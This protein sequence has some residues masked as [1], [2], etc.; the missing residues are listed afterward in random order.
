MIDS[1]SPAI[2]KRLSTK[3]SKRAAHPNATVGIEIGY[4]T[5]YMVKLKKASEGGLFAEK[6]KTFEFDP[7]LKI[8]SSGFATVLKNALKKFCGSSKELEIW[9]MP[10]LDKA[11]IH[12]IKIPNV[13][14]EGLPGAVYWGLQRE[15]AF[16]EDETVVD[17]QIEEGEETSAT[18]NITGA[19]I[20]RECVQDVQQAFSQTGYLLSG[21]GLPLLALRNLVNLHDDE[22]PE[23]PVLVCQ[24]GQLSTTVSVLLEKRL[25]FTRN[26]P[27]GLQS[28]AETLVKEYDSTLVQREACKIVLNLGLEE[29]KFSLEER[30]DH[31]QAFTLLRP[32][33]ERTVRQIKRTVEYYQSNFDSEPIETIF[34]GGEIAARG[35]LFGFIAQQL[36]SKVIAIDPF[37]SQEL[38][39]KSPPP[40]DKADRIAFGPAFGLAIEG[41]REGINFAHTYKE[42]QE[43]GKHNKLAITISALLIALL[44]AATIFYNSQRLDLLKLEAEQ[45]KLEENLKDLGPKLTEAIITE[46][47]EEVLSL[48]ER[49]RAATNRYESIALVSEITRLIPQNVSLLHVSAAMGSTISFLDPSA[50]TKKKSP[51]N[52]AA[53]RKGTLLLKGVVTGERTSLETSLT[54]YI[55]RL[56]QSR[57][58]HKVK[59]DSTELVSSSGKLHL[60]FTLSVETIDESSDITTN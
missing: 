23:A 41:T 52:S 56:D 31:E 5:I 38:H 12:H 20:E 32:V 17:F 15:D 4:G 35:K 22:K 27:L 59:V 21:I 10:K 49:R 7:S 47:S 33:L 1:D 37:D 2:S 44:V 46:A 30:Q 45:D 19:L 14:P 36:S 6:W 48:E 55:A 26:I 51:V 24:L 8:E 3:N 25:V 54:I 43:E 9:A 18:L 57:L 50:E 39:A 16:L 53:D 58:F 42:R 11:R 28:L 40:V 13:A 29:A 60:T 34:L